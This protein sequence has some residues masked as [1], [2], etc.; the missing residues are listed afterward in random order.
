MPI[1]KIKMSFTE[2]KVCPS[3][4]L[5]PVVKDDVSSK[6]AGIS[7]TAVILLLLVFGYYFQFD[8]VLPFWS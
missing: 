1:G 3:C 8:R 2:T 4:K 7:S 6:T 5:S